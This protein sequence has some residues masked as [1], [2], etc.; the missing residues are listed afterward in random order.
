MEFLVVLVLLIAIVIACLFTIPAWAWWVLCGIL[1]IR[2]R[3]QITG[4][5]CYVLRIPYSSKK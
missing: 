4:W 2:Y 5:V 3:K 1:V